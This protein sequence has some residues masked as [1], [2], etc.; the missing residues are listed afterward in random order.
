MKSTQ[1]SRLSASYFP[2]T[3][4][5][6]FS[7]AS[8]VYA[9]LF[10]AQ[11]MGFDEIG[12]LFAIWTLPVLILEIPSSILADRWRRRVLVAFASWLKAACFGLW[13]LAIIL[14]E[15]AFGFF[16]AGFVLWGVAEALS[17]GT[18][19]A[20]VY[21]ALSDE[22]REASYERFAGRGVF[23][24]RM[25]IVGAMA[26]GGLVYELSPLACMLAAAASAIA[27]SAFALGLPERRKAAPQGSAPREK[28]QGGFFSRLAEASGLKAVRGLG[29]VIL[30]GG[31]FL[32]AYGSLEEFDQLYVEALGM[33]PAMV[34]LWCAARFGVEGLGGLFAERLS[35]LGGPRGLIAIASASGA[36]LSLAAALPSYWTLPLYGLFYLLVAAAGV[37]IEARIQRGMGEGS[38]AAVLSVASLSYSGFGMAYGLVFGFIADDSD[39]AAAFLA[40]GM[41]S[42]AGSLALALKGSR[43]TR[44]RS[45][46]GEDMI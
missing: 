10:R 9:L 27:A 42:I 19:E 16:A 6:N 18:L 24:G 13:V 12:F 38:R 35:R 30:A 14:D 43:S 44:P 41:A 5:E 34:G 11:G 1:G 37:L 36:A 39:I 28:P 33:A 31:F 26:L 22:G 15:A 23:V 17:S 29:L 8:P 46:G 32:G 4:F 3:F 25:G 45:T 7:L 20:L 2:Y 21:E 40:G